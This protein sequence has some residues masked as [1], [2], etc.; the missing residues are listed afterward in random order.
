MSR[1]GIGCIS[2]LRCYAQCMRVNFNPGNSI[3][4]PNSSLFSYFIDYCKQT[5]SS[6][7][8]LN[9][10]L[11]IIKHDIKHFSRLKKNCDITQPLK[12]VLMIEP[13]CKKVQLPHL[14]RVM[15]HMSCVICQHITCHI[16][17]VT[18]YILFQLFVFSLKL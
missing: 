6:F 13:L 1:S 8:C 4:W 9:M 17:H 18:I 16:S 14:L 15:C 3:S 12:I 5:L 7:K 11:I 10:R 2:I